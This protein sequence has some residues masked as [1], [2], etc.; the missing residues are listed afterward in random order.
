MFG[1]SLTWATLAMLAGL[2]AYSFHV[3]PAAALPDGFTDTLVTDSS[4]TLVNDPSPLLPTALAFTPDGRMLVTSKPGKLYVYD[5]SADPAL[6]L[7]LN[8]GP[9]TCDNSERGL[10]GVSVDPRFGE[11]GHNYVYLY[12]TYNKYDQCP[13]GEPANNKNPVNRVSRFAMNG[14]TVDKSSERVLVDNIKSPNGNHNAGDLHFGKDG[15]LYVSV[16]DGACDYA[17]PARCQYENDASRDK[18]ILN[19][20]ILR[21]KP[22]GSIPADNPFLGTGTARCNETGQTSRGTYCQETY[23]KGF[24]NPFRFAIDPDASGT[25]LRVN[26]VGG[27]RWE[28]IDQ[29]RVGTGDDGNDYGWNLCEGRYDNPYHG[30]KVNCSGATYTAP[31]HEYSHNTG[32]ESI[33]GGAFVPDGFWPAKYDD[34][35]L[36]GDFV[37]GKIFTLNKARDRGY[38]AEVFKGGLG[39][40]SAVAMAFGPYGTTGKALYYTTFDNG[41]EIHRI[42]YTEGNQAPVADVKMASGTNNYGPMTMDFDASGSSDPDDNTPLTYVWNFGDGTPQT[43]STPASSHTYAQSR[44]YT[45]TL[46]VRDS[47][48]E[49]SEPTTINV[50]PGDTPPEPVIESPADESTFHLDEQIEASGSATDAEDDADGDPATG[51][52]LRW[53]VFQ[54]H[55]G[56]HAHPYTNGT[57]DSLTFLGADPEGLYSTDPD[58]NYLEVRLTATDSLGLSKTVSIELRPQT[59]AVTFG[60]QPKDLRLKINGDVFLAPK[61]IVSWEGYSLNAVA[62]RQRDPGG[63]L[64]GFQFWSDGGA[65]EH[66]IETPADPTTY[67][68]TIQ[69]IRR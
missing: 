57:G 31:I 54:H 43:T 66:V 45:V 64:W 7:V 62:P 4:D 21:I 69:R 11:D 25:V 46:T 16:G 27:Q 29:A 56:N 48:D 63:H 36:F 61:T 5:Q 58:L 23:L 50:F 10:L 20:K 59:V 1:R 17:E 40:Q 3:K 22:D 14:D 9:E 32:C 28:E 53:D 35:Y 2:L 52:T 67:T 26:D 49:P 12:Y 19:G 24:R 51:P 38:K 55:D 60:T 37:C 42:A 41:G 30:G 33:T 47:L 15:N 44:K 18:N 34:A 6:S 68:A 8:L 39:R 65:R 13:V